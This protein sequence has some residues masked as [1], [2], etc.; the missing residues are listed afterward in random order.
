MFIVQMFATTTTRSIDSLEQE[1]LA[2]QADKTRLVFRQVELLRHLDVAQVAA[3]D[4]CR[5]MIDWVASRLDVSRPVAKD[6]LVVARAQN[7]EIDRWLE[8][9]EIGLERAVALIRLHNTDAREELMADAIG[10]DLGGLWRLVTSR[11]RLTAEDEVKG[12]S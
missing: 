4:G 12:F 7:P 2:C 11:E 8:T 5:T 9:G 3:A 6:L 10:L 1:L